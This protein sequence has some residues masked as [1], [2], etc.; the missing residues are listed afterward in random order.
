MRRMHSAHRGA[1]VVLLAIIAAVCIAACG[2]SSAN[3]ASTSRTPSSTASAAAAT[4]RTAL[5]ACLKKHGVTLPSGGFHRPSNTGTAPSGGTPPSGGALG[6]G[7]A[8]GGHPGA[9]G[10]GAG[11]FGGGNSKLRT[12]LKDCGASFGTGTPGG[13]FAGGVAPKISTKVLDSYVA[14]IREHGDTAMPEPY[15]SSKTTPFPASAQTSAAFK[16][17]NAKCQSIITSAFR[18]GTGESSA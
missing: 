12:A 16:T 6:G 14:C 1:V 7:V 15:A 10:F 13:R 17:A 5:A 11:G 3:T 18:A 9:A 4:S 8:G 2:G